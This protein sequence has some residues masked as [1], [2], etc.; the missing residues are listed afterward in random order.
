[1][2]RPAPI[3]SSAR[4]SANL[5][6]PSQPSTSSAPPPPLAP[7]RQEEPATTSGPSQGPKYEF[8][9]PPSRNQDTS[10]D[11]FF[12]RLPHHILFTV[13]DVLLREAS[14]FSQ[15]Y[16]KM[17]FNIFGKPM[18]TVDIGQEVDYSGYEWFKD[19]PPPPQMVGGIPCSGC[20]S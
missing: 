11:Q 6:D 18:E 5:P 15:E 13:I 1:M 9:V 2:I 14:L 8:F 10:Q 3:H 17:S 20:R 16:T 12:Q 7:A 19:P 4:A